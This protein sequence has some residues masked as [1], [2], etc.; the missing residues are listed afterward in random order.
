MRK[1]S[2]G[3][4]SA[5]AALT[6]CGQLTGELASG[7]AHADVAPTAHA[8][9]A[10]TVLPSCQVPAPQVTG[11]VPL[12]LDTELPDGALVL[13]GSNLRAG[14]LVTVLHAVLPDCHRCRRGDFGREGPAWWR[15]RP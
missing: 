12:L 3:L 15:H 8:A 7:Q 6:I 10:A 5:L 2:M 9:V 14:K 11:P 13:G 1:V 4:L